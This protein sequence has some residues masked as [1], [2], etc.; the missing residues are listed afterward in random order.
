YARVHP[1]REDFVTG[2]LFLEARDAVVRTDRDHAAP[3]RVFGGGCGEREI[4]ATS[5]VKTDQCG[6]IQIGE[7]VAIQDHKRLVFV[8]EGPQRYQRPGGS[9][10]D[11]FDRVMDPEAVR[12]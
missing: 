1:R 6:Q 12:R 5:P 3:G 4:G 9:E 11:R 8:E 10:Q 7:Y 2:R